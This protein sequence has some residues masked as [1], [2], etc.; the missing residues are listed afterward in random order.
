MNI[1]GLFE[2]DKGDDEFDHAYSED[3]EPS[4]RISLSGNR[5]STD[6]LQEL[7]SPVLPD[8]HAQSCGSL[9]GGKHPNE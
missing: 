1:Y 4:D 3:N 2:S 7:G 8:S 9:V 6:S 5:R